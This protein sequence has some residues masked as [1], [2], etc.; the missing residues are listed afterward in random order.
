VL[1]KV[2]LFPALERYV[3]RFWRPRI[4]SHRVGGLV[5]LQDFYAR[6]LRKDSQAVLS[7]NIRQRAFSCPPTQVLSSPFFF[8]SFPG[9]LVFWTWRVCF[10]PRTNSRLYHFHWRAPPPPPPPPGLK[11]SEVIVA[12]TSF[13]RFV[14]CPRVC[15]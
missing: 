4:L 1:G 10:P 3:D 11:C 5:L 2:R 15:F 14:P 7:F 8:V 9:E 13:V 12:E 6:Q